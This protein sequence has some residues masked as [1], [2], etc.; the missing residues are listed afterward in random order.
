MTNYQIYTDG[1]CR[2]NGN[3]GDIGDL[4]DAMG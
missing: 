1:S 2:A 3:G 4:E